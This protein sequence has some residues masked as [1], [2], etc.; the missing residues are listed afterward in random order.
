[1]A[2]IAA[3]TVGFTAGC[4]NGARGPKHITK[5][6]I[7][8]QSSDLFERVTDVEKGG[9]NSA[10]LKLASSALEDGRCTILHAGDTVYVEDSKLFGPVQVRPKNSKKRYWTN[11]A[12]V[13]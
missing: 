1:L 8:C 3:A 13:Q 10:A 12:L 5:N 2:A 9:D 6:I 4:G 7:G 11:G